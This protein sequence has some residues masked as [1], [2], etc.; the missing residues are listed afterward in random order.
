VIANDGE[1]VLVLELDR[2]ISVLL[3]TW[4]EWVKSGVVVFASEG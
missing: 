3:V 1:N 4:R 2:K